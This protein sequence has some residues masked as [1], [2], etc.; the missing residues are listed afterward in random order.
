MGEPPSQLGAEKSTVAAA[1][2]DPAAR[3]ASFTV[4]GS[5]RM[6]FTDTVS[7]VVA[8]ELGSSASVAVQVTGVEPTANDAP[9]PGRHVTGSVTGPPEDDISFSSV[10]VGTV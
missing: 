6:G 4:G 7:D 1:D 8:C 10:A 5:G 3:A 2:P 9:G